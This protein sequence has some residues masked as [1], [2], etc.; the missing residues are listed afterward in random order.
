MKFESMC[1]FDLAVFGDIFFFFG[2]GGGIGCTFL[3]VC[4]SKY[5]KWLAVYG[6]IVKFRTLVTD[7]VG[8]SDLVVFKA[9]F[10]SVSTLV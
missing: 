7:I 10:K 6:N 5:S 2:G 3:A 9:I 1:T 4:I 8:T